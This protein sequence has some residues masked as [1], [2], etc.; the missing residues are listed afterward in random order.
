M[1][2]YKLTPIKGLS[3]TEKDIDGV[4]SLFLSFGFDDE[5]GDEEMDKFKSTLDEWYD[6]PFDKKII[7]CLDYEQDS[8]DPASKRSWLEVYI[9]TG[10]S[11]PEE[12]TPYLQELFQKLRQDLSLS[13]VEITLA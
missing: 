3:V 5:L 8:D 6:D 10:S 13:R 9:D 11:D 4:D 12:L 1:K 2:L 7:N